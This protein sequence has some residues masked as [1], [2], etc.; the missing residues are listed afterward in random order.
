MKWTTLVFAA[1]L[2]G[3]MAAHATTI[4]GARP[5]RSWTD[6][7]TTPSAAISNVANEDWVLGYLSGLAMG[8]QRDVLRSADYVALYQWVDDYCR[9]HPSADLGDAGQ[10]LFA[11]LRQRKGL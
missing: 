6:A 2:T 7:R 11:A 5:C 10:A 3:T 1:A 8:S 4:I 9:A